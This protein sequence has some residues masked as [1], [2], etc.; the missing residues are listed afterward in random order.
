MPPTWM[1]RLPQVL[2]WSGVS[3]RVAGDEMTWLIGTSSSSATIC[4]SA[5]VMPV[6]RST[7]PE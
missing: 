2:P 7:L 3:M 1:V 6:P 5:V 4:R